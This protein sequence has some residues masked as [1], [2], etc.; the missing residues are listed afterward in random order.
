[1]HASNSLTESAISIS[2]SSKMHTR[3][4]S[5]LVANQVVMGVPHLKPPA[6]Q[7]ST[8]FAKQLC[9]VLHA[10]LAGLSDL[11]QFVT[12]SVLLQPI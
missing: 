2:S 12:V 11:R 6:L 7:Y 5:N 1:M 8:L 4:L 3:F 9:D 10:L